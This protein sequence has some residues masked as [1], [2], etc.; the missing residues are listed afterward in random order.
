MMNQLK[1][2]ITVMLFPIIGHAQ[3]K[4]MSGNDT[5]PNTVE[6][7]LK[8]F[9][10]ASDFLFSTLSEN[11]EGDD[12]G[13]NMY[14]FLKIFSKRLEEPEDFFRLQVDAKKFKT[15]NASLESIYDGFFPVHIYIY[16]KV[17]VYKNQVLSNHIS[18]KTRDTII[19][20]IPTN[21][22]CYVPR[23]TFF[24]GTFKISFAEQ[25]LA[26]KTDSKVKSEIRPLLDFNNGYSAFNFSFDFSTRYDEEQ[27][28][29]IYKLE[30]N[31]ILTSLVFWEYLTDCANYDLNTRKYFY[32]E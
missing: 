10:E 4:A 17:P 30:Y 12:K 5:I 14:T 24:Q 28:N 7:K 25:L 26:D 27:F 9:S 1:F 8:T 13:E 15:L 18:N 32:E 22:P 11:F 20:K 3:F 2:I 6:Q 29:E 23:N 31:R 16:E 21:M 19:D